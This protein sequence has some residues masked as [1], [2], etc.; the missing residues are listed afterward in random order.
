MQE[1]QFWNQFE[2]YLHDQRDELDVE[3]P[4]AEVW[5]RI[6]DDLGGRTRPLWQQ[7][8]LWRVAAVIAIALG[9]S[10]WWYSRPSDQLPQMGADIGA[11]HQDWNTVST[12][13]QTEIDS[14]RAVVGSR[15]DEMPAWQQAERR[16]DSLQAAGAPTPERL[17]L[18]QHLRQRQ[19]EVLRDVTP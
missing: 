8:Q 16:I 10:Y 17:E 13:Y 5:D 14:L 11:G 19:V 1:N 4:R 9:L 7:A 12:P 15:A 18:Y 2:T 3:T 6:A